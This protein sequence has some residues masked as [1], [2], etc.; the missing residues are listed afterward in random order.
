MMEP[1][2][3]SLAILTYHSLDTSGSV[4]SVAPKAFEAQMDTLAAAGVRGV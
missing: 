4:V 1:T 2:G 3:N